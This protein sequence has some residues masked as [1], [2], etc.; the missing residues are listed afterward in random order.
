MR[1]NDASDAIRTHDLVLENLENR[2]AQL[3]LFGHFCC[4]LAVQPECAM[5]EKISGFLKVKEVSAKAV[6]M[7]MS[8]PSINHF[9]ESIYWGK[10]KNFQ[11]ELWNKKLS[12]PNDSTLR[13]SSKNY[14][15]LHDDL[16]PDLSIPVNQKTKLKVGSQALTIHNQD[17]EKCYVISTTTNGRDVVGDIK[18]WA[19]NIEQTAIDSIVWQP[20]SS[21]A[22]AMEIPSPSPS[23][24]P[25][26]L[27]PR[28]PGTLYDETPIQGIK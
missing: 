11:L 25:M 21:C 23:R 20:V 13:K 12:N 4:R 8:S 6:S 16:H 24:V 19:K 14:D 26:F 27:R 1:L 18:L 28:A 17:P 7:S 22:S 5:Q 10:I 15:D 9:S 3:P 2:Q